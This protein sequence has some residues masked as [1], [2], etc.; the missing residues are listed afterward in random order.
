[1]PVAS[2]G[3]LDEAHE[4]EDAASEGIEAADRA[5]DAGR[6]RCRQDE[7]HE[8]ESATSD[9]IE[10]PGR[11]VDAGRGRA[12]ELPMP[13]RTTRGAAEPKAARRATLAWVSAAD[14]SAGEAETVTGQEASASVTLCS[15]AS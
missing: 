12:T 15:S 5:G 14:G 10:A 3:R 13:G 11:A 6:G 4:L 8:L 2:D 9:G 1:M 7:A